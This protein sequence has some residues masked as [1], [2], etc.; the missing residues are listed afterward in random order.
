MHKPNHWLRFLR[1]W[2]RSSCCM[3]SSL[4]LSL[5]SHATNGL[6]GLPVLCLVGLPVMDMELFDRWVYL[7]MKPL[8]QMM[9]MLQPLP[10]PQLPKQVGI[11]TALISLFKLFLL[12]WL[13]RVAHSLVN[14]SWSKIIRYH[15]ILYVLLY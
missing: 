8:L 3:L 7:S 11:L 14:Q 15:L 6:F 1:L 4:H 12:P 13:L 5:L 2:N 10:H 9:M